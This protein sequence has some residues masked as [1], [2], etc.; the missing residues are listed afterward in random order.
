MGKGGKRDGISN[1]F[2]DFQL[3]T[4]TQQKGRAMKPGL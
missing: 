4:F 2:P 1:P 3:S